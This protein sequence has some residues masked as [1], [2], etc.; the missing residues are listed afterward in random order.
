MD[1][2]AALRPC[3]IDVQ[4]GPW[5]YTIPAL[6]AADWIEAIVD[7]EGGSVVPGLMDEETQRDVWR[8]YLRGQIESAELSDGWRHALGA[9]TG[10]KWWSAAKLFLGATDPKTWPAL[11]G[12]LLIRGIDLERVSVGAAWN[13]IYVIG[14]EG[15]K[16]EAERAKFEFD[17]AQPP[18]GVPMSEA[19]DKAEAAS[20]F[21]A[22][23]GVLRSVDDG[24]TPG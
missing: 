4:L 20:D 11:H 19:Y 3:A 24:R 18:P 13:A 2:V 16:D 1:V 21:L 14:M 9:A 15:C 5:I 22:A 17:L 7:P 8:C 6:P 12:Q 23:M 10:Q